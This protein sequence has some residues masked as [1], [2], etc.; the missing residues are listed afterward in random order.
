MLTR[1]DRFWSLV[2]IA[3][4]V[5]GMS[6][7]T[8][9]GL[10]ADQTLVVGLVAEP[11]NLDCAQV[12]DFN[13]TRAGRRILESLVDFDDQTTELV[14][15]LAQSW[16]VSKD[17]LEYTFKLQPGI[18]FQDGTPLNAEAVRFS[19]DR[20]I[21]EEAPSHKLGWY[22]Y[23]KFFFGTIKSIAV[24]DDLTVKFTL[25]EPRASF[26][27][28][29]AT[30]AGGIVSPTTYAKL[31]K[32][33]ASRPVGTGPFQYAN[34]EHGSQI[35]MERNPTYWRRGGPRLQKIAYRWV[36]DDQTRLAQLQNGTLDLVVDVPPDSIAGLEKDPRFTVLKSAGMHVWYVGINTTHGPLRDKR[37]RQALNYAVDKVAIT[38]DV[39]KGTGVPAISPINPGTWGFEPAVT[40][41][42]YNPATAKKLLAE[43]GYPNGFAVN[44]WTP[45]SGSGMQAPVAM[46]T[47]IQANL[48]AVGVQAKIQT[49]EWGAF[50]KRLTTREQD[51]FAL[52]W[53]AGLP[54]P[55]FVLY[56]LFHSSQWTPDGPNRALYKN[57][58]YDAL[59]GAAR[60]ITEI[61]LR[62]RL[63]S[64][65]QKMLVDEAPWIFV[66]HQIQ[67]M[68]TKA[69]VK[70]FRPHPNFDTR[71][72]NVYR[73]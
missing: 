4:L 36:A 37:V 48:Q 46:S 63:Y 57:E 10:A 15:G 69:S 66:D 19:F 53:A 12:T 22:P 7:V 71:L 73:Q 8:T 64:D 38:R 24:I 27:G 5:L 34:W 33:F 35:I 40:R 51:L 20:Q 29:M 56:P 1:C 18:K 9:S 59:L 2:A 67:V 31:G 16:T 28:T 17:G 60:K 44:F 52:S 25:S 62:K 47:V 65:A 42:D 41:Y 45:E 32:D 72:T 55:D 30:A 23:A 3:G 26:I 68:V 43:A 14:P 21:N 11:V 49:M 50:L 54:D 58:R 70:G 39:L 6:L 61:P 13:S